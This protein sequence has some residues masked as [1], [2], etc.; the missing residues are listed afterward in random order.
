MIDNFRDIEGSEYW[1]TVVEVKKGWSSDRKYH[2][3]CNNNEELLLRVSDGDTFE[4][5]EKEYAV[6]EHLSRLDYSMSEAIAF[7]VCHEGV[8]MLL[9]WVKGKSMEEELPLLS[10]TEQYNLGLQSGKILQQIHNAKLESPVFSWEEMFNKKMDRKIEMYSNCSTKYRNGHLFIDYINKS[11]SLLSDRP[12]VLQHGDYHCGNMIYTIDGDVGIID[13][14][15]Y[16]FGDP[17]EEFNRIVWDVD[18]SHY[19]AAGRIDGYFDNDVPHE[20]FDL[21]ALYISSNTLSS[22]PW[23]VPFGEKEVETMKLQARMILEYYDNFSTT[24][25]SWYSQSKEELMSSKHTST[26]C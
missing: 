9:K 13:F 23:A 4:A 2:I 7:G 14:N 16:D 26:D 5:K 19:F 20:F 11:R 18:C 8:Y 1:K 6:I 10:I 22:L 3:V 21:L 12:I 15:R 24:I 25:P 17:W